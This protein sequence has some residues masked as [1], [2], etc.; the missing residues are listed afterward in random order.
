M[1]EMRVRLLGIGACCLELPHLRIFVD[2]FNEFVQVKDLK[3]E[4]IILFT[5][6]DGDHFKVE[7]FLKCYKNNRVIAPP[8][9]IEKILG[10]NLPKDRIQSVY[11]P[12]E[13][14]PQ[15]VEIESIKLSVYQTQHFIDWHPIHV[16]FIVEY[17]G[18]R[19]YLTGDSFIN[20]IT[21]KALY[22][23]DLLVMSLIKK[24]VV[25]A[26]MD[27]ATGSIYHLAEIN[28]ILYRFKPAQIL[29]NHMLNCSWAVDSKDMKMRLA[30]NGFK[31]VC[32]LES[33]QEFILI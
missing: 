10:C 30:M 14:N 18:K 22:G 21:G 8:S 11:P 31:Q 12:E 5:H 9:V 20:D 4:D 32:V 25:K 2:A 16:S 15:I 29:C 33:P 26:Q 19:I 28:D 1:N 7:P 23:A 6:A 17:K 13:E 24:E 27:S 3:E